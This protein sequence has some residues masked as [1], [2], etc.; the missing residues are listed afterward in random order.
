VKFK[1][2]KFEQWGSK[3]GGWGI[4]G[5]WA[6]APKLTTAS[7]SPGDLEKNGFCLGGIG[8]HSGEIWGFEVWLFL[9]FWRNLAYYCSELCRQIFD[10]FDGVRQPHVASNDAENLTKIKFDNFEQCAL[11]L[12]TIAVSTIFSRC[13]RP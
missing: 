12:G 3:F 1:F 10:F 7:Y 6:H 4:L 8:P 2:V 11:E 9:A 13:R 5:F